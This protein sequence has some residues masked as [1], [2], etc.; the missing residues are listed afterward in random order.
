MGFVLLSSKKATLPVTAEA[1]LLTF[2]WDGSA[3]E[4]KGKDEFQGG[5]YQDLD[6]QAFMQQLLDTATQIWNDVPS[7]FVTLA[8]AQGDGALDAE[9]GVFSIVTEKSD[10][11]S[12][13]AYASPQMEEDDDGDA[14]TETIKDCD[15]AIADN[16][17]EAKSLAYTILHELGHCL[18]L[19]HAHTN[20][21]AV[22]SYSRES[23]SLRLGADDMAGLIYLYPD[24]NDIPDEPKEVVCGVVG[25]GGARHS[26]LNVL[27]MLLLPLLFAIVSARRL[28]GA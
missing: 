7:A 13:A 16:K 19:G 2:V 15:I 1:P 21:N 26:P 12:S 28:T 6:D 18:G 14:T 17:V 24:P 8:V 10:N 23:Q 25:H 9:D 20:Y 4:I 11:L 27:G 3:P 5:A 22:M